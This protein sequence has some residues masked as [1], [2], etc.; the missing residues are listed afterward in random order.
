MSRVIVFPTPPPPN[1]PIDQAWLHPE[2]PAGDSS[3]SRQLPEVEIQVS[4]R[5]TIWHRKDRADRDVLGG[6]LATESTPTSIQVKSAVNSGPSSAPFLR[7]SIGSST[8]E[9]LLC[10][11]GAPVRTFWKEDVRRRAHVCSRAES[12][13]DVAQHRTA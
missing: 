13:P 7:L 8:S 5:H 11:L 3:L 9:D 6:Q 12:Q 4:P 1:V 10:D 2:L